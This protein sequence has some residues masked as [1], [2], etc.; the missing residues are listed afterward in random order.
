MQY[1]AILIGNKDTW[2]WTKE[3]ETDIDNVYNNKRKW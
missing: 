1:V 2:L 3:K